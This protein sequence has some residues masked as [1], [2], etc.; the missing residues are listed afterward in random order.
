MKNS[1]VSIISNE[2]IAAGIYEMKL[3]L[4]QGEHAELRAGQF[5][6]I[7]ITGQYLRR[8]IS[9]CDWTDDTLTVIYKV[10]GKGTEAMR[11][12]QAGETLDILWPLGN[13]FAAGSSGSGQ[14]QEL[15]PGCS[16]EIQPGQPVLIGGGVGVPPMVCLCKRLL[17]E[18]QKPIVILGFRSR[19]DVF[20]QDAFEA[21]GVQTIVTRSRRHRVQVPD[22]GILPQG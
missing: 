12:M 10:V 4:P 13:G 9:I 20:Y 2:R 8:P 7:R 11:A 1:I 16:Q 14:P 19:E 5:I 3:Q 17:G 6:N 21:L 18:G 22:F 15:Q